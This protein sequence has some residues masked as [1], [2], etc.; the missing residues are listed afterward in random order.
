MLLGYRKDTQVRGHRQKT[1]QINFEMFIPDILC[2]HSFHARTKSS[3]LGGDDISHYKRNIPHKE[4]R[5][6]VTQIH[7]RQ[8]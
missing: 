6:N 5:S 8:G 2:S 4:K 7:T 3:G 1:M